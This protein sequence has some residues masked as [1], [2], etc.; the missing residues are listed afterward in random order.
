MGK[1]PYTCPRCNYSTVEKNNMR[2]HLYGVQKV[3]PATHN[4]IE[5]TDEVKEYIM[6]NR[7]YRKVDTATNEASS[8]TVGSKNVI[9]NSLI[10]RQSDKYYQETVE[11]YL[12]GTHKQLA[13]SLVDVST[14]T[15]HAIIKEWTNYLTALG[16]LL[17]YKLAD[18]KDRL[19]V[20]FFGNTSDME[21]DVEF[22]NNLFLS[23]SIECYTFVEMPGKI[24]IIDLVT[25]HSVF[26]Y[27]ITKKN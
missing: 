3:C 6:N 17:I 19:Q 10:T 7:I 13:C 9:D 24:S 22:I 8:S 25:N 12:G 11:K 27:K 20:Y 14:D 26:E 1:T 21:V 2:K 16:E 5:L 4:D 15:T 18:P 23:H